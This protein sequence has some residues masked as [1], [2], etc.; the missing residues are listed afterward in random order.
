MDDICLKKATAQ[1]QFC[2]GLIAPVIQGLYP[3][4]SETAYFKRITENPIT[5]PDGTSRKLSYK[6]LQ[7]WT[8]KYRRGGLDALM[9][10][11]RADKGTPRSLPD[12]A[13]EEIFR[14]KNEFPRINSTQIHH[15]LVE[16]G[17]ITG[18]VSVDSVQRFVKN[19]GL[20]GAV[21]PNMRDRKAFEEDA[22]GK[23][24]QA[25]TCYIFRMN[26]NGKSRQVYCMA[27]IDDHSRML[28]G[29]DVFFNDNASNFQKV[30]KDAI[31]THGIP[32]KLMV[33]N[34]AP[35]TNE[36]L[37]LICVALG[38]QLIHTRPRDGA[39]KGKC[40]RQWLTMKET[41]LYKLNT[42]DINSLEAFRPMLRDYIR[43]YNTSRHSGIGC[44]PMERYSASDK[45]VRAPRSNE[46][47]N[48]CF[49]NRITRKVRKDSTVS[50]DKVSYDVPMQFIGMKVD[51][52]F[53]PG[54]MGD[55]YILYEGTKSPIR[56]TDKVA[57]CHT[58]RNNGPV[59]DYS[60]IGGVS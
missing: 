3:D 36:Q 12:T 54:D 10:K 16:N 19:N 32:A 25:D 2:F 41:W 39:S 56:V 5:F 30:L 60:R 43:R 29:A 48:E 31:G 28:V 37:S 47:L 6:T 53:L 13:I 22:F 46:W 23:M 21:N 26:E 8:S 4:A 20:K 11:E 14:L 52:R 58:K 59:L 50:I 24:W 7:D 44:S 51:I 34:G 49:Y 18:S 35:Y 15:S 55:A 33:D 1:A 9:P 17:F 45:A 38:I 40:E 27:I 42:N 57:N